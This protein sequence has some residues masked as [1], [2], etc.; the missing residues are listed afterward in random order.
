MR[1]IDT[2]VL[3]T[4]PVTFSLLLVHFPQ[5]N[6]GEVDLES[7]LIT[8]G[9]ETD[10]ALHPLLARRRTHVR[11]ADVVAQLLLDLLHRIAPAPAAAAR[12]SA[13]VAALLAIGA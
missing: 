13:A 3:S 1:A 11:D 4:E 12:V 9:L 5:V 6:R 2:F 7:A 10:V 8:E